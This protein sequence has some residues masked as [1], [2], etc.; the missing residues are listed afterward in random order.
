MN[1]YLKSIICV[2]NVSY[3]NT[4]T[5]VKQTQIDKLNF[6]FTLGQISFP[7]FFEAKC[8]KLSRDIGKKSKMGFLLNISK[9]VVSKS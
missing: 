4:N 8:T 6:Q 9:N 1:I 5:T 2:R 7:V 3:A